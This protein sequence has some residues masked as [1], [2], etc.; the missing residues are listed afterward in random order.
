[1]NE[2][3]YIREVKQNLPRVLALIDSD[4][5]SISYGLGDRFY[6]AWGLIDFGNATYQ[7]FAHG[8]S[9]LWVSGLWPYPTSK[10]RFFEQI[11]ALFLGAKNLTRNDGSLEEAFPNEGSYCV[12][13]LV[14]FD[15]L[16]ALDLLSSETE[17]QLHLEWEKI[18]EPIIGYLIKS[19]ET[20]AII[21]NHLATAVA[22]L[23]RWHVL[24][25]ET[26]AEI[27]AQKLL[28]RILEYQSTTEGWFR[29]YEG[30]DPGYQTLCTYYLADVNIMRPDWELT[31]HLKKSLKFLSYFANPD[32]SF[33]GLY[34]SRNTRF[35]YPAGIL[36]LADE[37]EYAAGLAQFMAESIKEQRVVTLSAMDEPNFAP[38]FNAYCWA[39]QL[40]NDRE[41]KLKTTTLP[42]RSDSPFR[43]HFPEAGLMIDA[44][45][46][47]YTLVNIKKG[48][49]VTHFSKDSLLLLDAG[50]V[51][52]NSKGQL[53]STQAF[54]DN[55]NFELD[56]DILTIDSTF[57]PMPKRLPNPFQ[58]IVLRLLGITFFRF[59]ILREWAKQF[60]VRLLISPQKKWPINN[61]RKII[62]GSK[63]SITDT[64][65][66]SKGYTKFENPGSFVSVHM[67]SQGYW[68]VQDE[69]NR[70]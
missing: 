65:S 45:I 8:M 21:S 39:A 14:A 32:G 43:K 20:H 27:K 31:N 33:G 10:E 54:N 24:T 40:E 18:I 25:G 53:G 58:F 49:V 34:G 26:A 56:G 17:D 69:E 41:G 3:I 42:S 67:A 68:Q 2:S 23:V 44:N 13:A 36:A 7:G 12:S 11:N 51:I 37:S 15:L 62:L 29:E 19:D 30:A 35:I 66:L 4:R 50:A 60:L 57:V 70:N 64:Y 1:M 46:N 28:K 6:W 61:K 59:R 16:C 22:A 48:G 5:T 9:R 52:R 38:M 55:N 47:H 63:L